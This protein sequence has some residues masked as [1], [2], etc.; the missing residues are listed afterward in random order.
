MVG[1]N[2]RY[3]QCGKVCTVGYVRVDL[4]IDTAYRG[5]PNFGRI[6]NFVHGACNAKSVGIF[7]SGF[8]NDAVQAY[9]LATTAGD[10]TGTPVTWLIRYGTQ[11]AFEYM[12]PGPMGINANFILCSLVWI[13]IERLDFARNILGK[14]VVA[15][16][17]EDEI[18]DYGLFQCARYI[19][20]GLGM[21]QCTDVQIQP[22]YQILQGRHL[23]GS[24]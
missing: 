22:I 8:Q 17:N 12:Q 13:G 14:G 10:P 7:S 3:I 19:D 18:I 1:G 11:P 16:G 23:T 4:Q 6:G 21:P 15:L 9:C 20:A 24:H 2:V 5:R